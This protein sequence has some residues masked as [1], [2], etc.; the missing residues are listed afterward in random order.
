M[1]WAYEG[2]GTALMQSG[3]MD[4]AIADFTRAIELDPEIVWAYYNRGLA[5]VYI[6]NES[7]AQKDFSECLKLRPDL[8]AELDAKIDLARELREEHKS[9]Q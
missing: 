8:K 5:R 9:P 2:R 7:D 1:A 6:G 4:K 3:K